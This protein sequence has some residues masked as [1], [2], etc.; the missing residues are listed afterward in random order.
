MFHETTFNATL[1]QVFEWLSKACNMLPQQNNA[2][3]VALCTMLRDV[4]IYRNNVTLKIVIKNR[5]L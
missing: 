2:L 3:K 4:D 1:L 5:L